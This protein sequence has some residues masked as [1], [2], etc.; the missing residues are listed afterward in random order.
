MKRRSNTLEAGKRRRVRRGGF[1]LVEALAAGII[2]AV[3]GAVV[4]ASLAQTYESLRV[5]KDEQHAAE[6]LDG[7]L[8]RIDLIGPDRLG[9]EGPSEGRCA[10]DD[11]FSWR[12]QFRP[13]E[14]GHLYE[15]TVTVSWSTPRGLRSV[16]AQTYLND[17]PG[18][19][20]ATLSWEAL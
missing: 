7:V 19:R 8:T 1:T 3:G 10:E 2:L 6:L 14:I 17:P 15:V 16:E 13:L 9:R 4:G 12:A 11:R 5:A 20:D 18:S